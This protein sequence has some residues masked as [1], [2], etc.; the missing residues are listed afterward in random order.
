MTHTR[1]YFLSQYNILTYYFIVLFSNT[2]FDELPE[3]GWN[4]R[5]VIKQDTNEK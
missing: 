5:F 4:I 2:V 3:L 1:Y